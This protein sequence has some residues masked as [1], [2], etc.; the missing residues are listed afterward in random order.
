M[1]QQSGCLWRRKVLAVII[2]DSIIK[3]AIAKYDFCRKIVIDKNNE[4]ICKK[5]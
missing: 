3:I 5:D 2:N 1:G 4:Y